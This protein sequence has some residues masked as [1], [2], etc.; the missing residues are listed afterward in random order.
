MARVVET[1]GVSEAAT[2]VCVEIDVAGGSIVGVGMFVDVSEA[3]TAV[4]VGGKVNAGPD[5][6][7]KTRG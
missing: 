3:A 6:S 5:G 2:A 1:V 7:P 4:G